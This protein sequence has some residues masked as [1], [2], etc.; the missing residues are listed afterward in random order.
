MT[1]RALTPAAR[2]VLATVRAACRA[3]RVDL[4]D[5]ADGSTLVIVLSDDGADLLRAVVRAV[6]RVGDPRQLALPGVPVVP[7]PAVV[8]PQPIELDA[9][10]ADLDD[11]GPA[12]IH[13]VCVGDRLTLDEEP[14][15][16]M[17]VDEQGFMWRTVATDARGRS[18]DE[19]ECYWNEVTDLGGGA[20]IVREVDTETPTQRAARE[21]A[22]ARASKPKAPA[23]ARPARL[24]P[25]PGADALAVRGV[26]CV[27]TQLHKGDPWEL[28][29]SDH[30][31]RQMV[32]DEAWKAVQEQAARARRYNRGQRCVADTADGRTS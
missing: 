16:V 32:C 22:E 9:A 6:V 23:K 29:W 27:I 30:M 28:M 26:R 14:I 7:R 12:P 8:P 13:G 11:D 5:Q 20:W 18:D 19:G 31:P 1:R 21:R 15:E 25:E 4:A 17:G 10:P 24:T 3:G 2:A